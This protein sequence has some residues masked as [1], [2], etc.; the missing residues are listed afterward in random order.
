MEVREVTLS[1]KEL[2]LEPLRL[3]H[4][5]E[6]WEGGA[7]QE[8][9]FQHMAPGAEQG[10][11]PFQAWVARRLEDAEQDNALPF[12]VR[13]KQTGLPLGS[14]SMF[15]IS[16]RHHRLEI[17]HTWFRKEWR[18][19][20]ANPE[21]KLLLMT[22]AFEEMDAVRV[23]FKVDVRNEAAQKALERIGAVKEGQMRSERILT[24]G[25]VRDA[26]VYSIIKREWP[27][28]KTQLNSIVWG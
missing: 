14:T 8:G 5:K 2:L 23:Q 21:T 18:G 12:M 16:S 20:K 26:Y 4:A 25:F 10:F 24:D 27:D 15:N 22:H 9:T 3:K 1:G 13:G 17:G 11:R 28:V 19:S 6:L 7:A